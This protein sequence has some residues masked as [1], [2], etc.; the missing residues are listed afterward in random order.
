MSVMVEVSPQPSERSSVEGFRLLP[1]RF[2]PEA[3]AALLAEVLAAAEQAPFRS[4]VTPWGKPMSVEMTNM[5][6]LGWHTDADG[7][8]YVPR[9]PVTAEPW[10]PI[11][12]AALDLWAE[13]A[14]EAPP[15]DSCLVNL[16]RG[17]AK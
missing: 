9:H 3:Q 17:A 1:G 8:R 15:P 6:P 10:P 2:S 7:Y 5:G 14:P 4:P 12:A 16:Y 11:P 13:L